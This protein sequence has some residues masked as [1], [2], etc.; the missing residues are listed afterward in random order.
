MIIAMVWLA[1]AVC[2]DLYVITQKTTGSSIAS[3][4][5]CSDCSRLLLRGVVRLQL[6]QEASVLSVGAGFSR[7]GRT[8]F[9]SLR[10]GRAARAG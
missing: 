10:G 8:K 9:G 1:L 5:C 6:L 2:G 7:R 4:P 3:A